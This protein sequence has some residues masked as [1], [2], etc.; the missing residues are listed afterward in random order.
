MS[1]ADHIANLE[2]EARIPHS[3]VTESEEELCKAGEELEATRERKV[4]EVTV[5]TGFWGSVRNLAS[6]STSCLTAPTRRP[7]PGVSSFLGRFWLAISSDGT[8]SSIY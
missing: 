7:E 4:G 6:G 8:P 3:R 1:P 5:L 2:E